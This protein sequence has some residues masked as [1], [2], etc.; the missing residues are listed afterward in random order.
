MEKRHVA[1]L[2]DY[3]TAFWSCVDMSGEC[4]LWM[5]GR[6]Q[7]GYGVTRARSGTRGVASRVAW[8]L[9]HGAPPAGACVLHSCDNPPCCNPAHLFLGTQADNMR[10]KA[11]KGR[12]HRLRGAKNGN[13][14]LTAD[15]VRAIRLRCS[16]GETQVDVAH[17]IGV[18]RRAVWGIVHGKTWT[19]VE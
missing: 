16:S 11:A 18:S 4:W 6:N 2:D 12:A 10:D 17:S 15:D 5:R 1:G 3:A 7:Y 19:H 13:S 9:T 14:I 8:E